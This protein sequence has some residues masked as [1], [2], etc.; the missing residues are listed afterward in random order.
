MLYQL[1]YM[2]TDRLDAAVEVRRL[3]QPTTVV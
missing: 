1:S 2:P 3:S